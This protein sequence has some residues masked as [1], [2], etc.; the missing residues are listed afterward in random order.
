MTAFSSIIVLERRLDQHSFSSDYIIDRC[1]QLLQLTVDVINS[2]FSNTVHFF[3]PIRKS[4]IVDQISIKSILINQH[5]GF[6]LVNMTFKHHT[7]CTSELI[8]LN[9]SFPKPIIVYKELFDSDLFFE[10]F[11][12][13]SPFQSFYL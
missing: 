13:Q 11:F 12:F 10:H 2:S 5:P 9:S 3:H 6:L 7:Q 4:N 1:Q 8:F